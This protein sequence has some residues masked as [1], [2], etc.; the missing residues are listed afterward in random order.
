MENMFFSWN[1]HL[2][3]NTIMKLWNYFSQNDFFFKLFYQIHW[4]IHKI[5]KKNLFVD[6]KRRISALETYSPPYYLYLKSI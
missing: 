3:W 6:H 5:Y 1:K 2:H 4:F